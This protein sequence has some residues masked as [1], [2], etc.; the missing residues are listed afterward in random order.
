MRKLKIHIPEGI[1]E[2]SRG[3][4]SD[5]DDHPRVAIRQASAPR[6]AC[7]NGGNTTDDKALCDP[8]PGSN[9]LVTPNPGCSSLSPLDPGLPSPIPAGIESPIALD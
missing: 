9:R 6:R 1:T 2:I 7:Q 4:R 3:S 8:L 5:S